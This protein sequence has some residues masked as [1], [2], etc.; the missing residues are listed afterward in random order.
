MKVNEMVFFDALR[1]IGKRLDEAYMHAI[2]PMYPLKTVEDYKKRNSIFWESID[3]VKE[4]KEDLELLLT[5]VTEDVGELVL[6]GMHARSKAVLYE[7]MDIHPPMQGSPIGAAVA[8]PVA[9]KPVED[10]EKKAEG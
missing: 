9:L 3:A 7:M 10:E 1:N 8:Q 4:A 6:H 5:L 2:M